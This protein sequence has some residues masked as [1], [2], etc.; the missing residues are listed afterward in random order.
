MP[1]PR[2]PHAL[3]DI[4]ALEATSL[5]IHALQAAGV[6]KWLPMNPYYVPPG[7]SRLQ[8]LRNVFSAPQGIIVPLVTKIPLSA[9]T[10]ATTTTL[11][12]QNARFVRQEEIAPH[13]TA[14]NL[15]RGDS[16]VWRVKLV[17]MCALRGH[18][19]KQEHQAVNR[20]LQDISAMIH[21]YSLRH[22]LWV[23]SL[24]MGL[25]TVPCVQLVCTSVCVYTASECVNMYSS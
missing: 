14:P 11:A 17:V 22:A 13:T 20:A 10:V 1:Q 23:T 2:P 24:M 9:L 12:N 5:V 19:V 16:S 6:L 7:Y 25:P 8:H 21:H 3:Q 18:S 15:A 4:T